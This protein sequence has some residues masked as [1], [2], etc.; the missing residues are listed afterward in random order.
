MIFGL[1]TSTFTP[2]AGR[3]E[4]VEKVPALSALGR[5]GLAPGKPEAFT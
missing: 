5:Y 2:S 3:T 1:T 4:H